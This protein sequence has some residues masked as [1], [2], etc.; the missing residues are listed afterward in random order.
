MDALLNRDVLLGRC[1]QCTALARHVW[2]QLRGD[3]L[4]GTRSHREFAYGAVQA[5]YG[6]SRALIELR[7]RELERGI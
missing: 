2:A 7:V 1:R 4:L 6:R 5:H 3:P